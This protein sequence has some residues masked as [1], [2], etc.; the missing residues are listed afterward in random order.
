MGIAQLL[1]TALSGHSV[2]RAVIGD[3]DGNSTV[4]IVSMVPTP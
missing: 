4:I 1:L 2:A 3:M